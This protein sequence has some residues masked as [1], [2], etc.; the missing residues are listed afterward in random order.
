MVSRPARI[1]ASTSRREASAGARQHLLQPLGIAPRGRHRRTP[2]SARALR[3]A[4][5]RLRR[6][7]AAPG[8]AFS[9]PGRAGGHQLR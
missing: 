5:R 6:G 1:H 3:S 8:A 9:R 7:C 4:R 2:G